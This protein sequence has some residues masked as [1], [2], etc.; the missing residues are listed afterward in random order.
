MVHV[1]EKGVLDFLRANA[2]AANVDHLV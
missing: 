2:I 1:E